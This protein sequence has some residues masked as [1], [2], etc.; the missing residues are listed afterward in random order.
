[1]A[2]KKAKIVK[3]VKEKKVKVVLIE[4]TEEITEPTVDE[5]IEELDEIIWPSYW[6]DEVNLP[7]K[8]RRP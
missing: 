3:P 8:R 4:P 7:T 5:L 6:E 1:M 2:V